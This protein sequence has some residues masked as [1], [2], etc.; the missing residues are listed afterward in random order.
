MNKAPST[1]PTAAPARKSFMRLAQGKTLVSS[2]VKEAKRVGYTV[3]NNG[4]FSYH[5]TDHSPEAATPGAEVFRAVNVRPG[6]WAISYAL[7]YFIEPEPVLPATP[8]NL[9]KHLANHP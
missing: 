4:G 8:A 2:L 6:M 9:A 3:K 1:P 5:V 7:A